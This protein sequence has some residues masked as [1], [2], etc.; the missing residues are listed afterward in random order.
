M[1]PTLTVLRL[2]AKVGSFAKISRDDVTSPVH[3]FRK[4]CHA[5]RTGGHRTVLISVK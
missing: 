3:G 1:G 2:G 5:D 4:Q